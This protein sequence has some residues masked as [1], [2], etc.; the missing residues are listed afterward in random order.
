MTIVNSETAANI[1]EAKKLKRRQKQ[2]KAGEPFTFVTRKVTNCGWATKPTPISARRRLSS[3]SLDGK[4]MDVLWRTAAK[5]RLFAK[6]ATMAN[7]T[8]EAAFTE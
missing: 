6:I 3:R 2:A 5:T 4:R 8:F 7:R 1:N